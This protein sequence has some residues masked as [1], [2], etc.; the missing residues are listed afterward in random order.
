MR[1]R[2]SAYLLELLLL[3]LQQLALLLEVLI[4]LR[5][6]HKLDPRKHALT[7]L[8]MSDHSSR[9]RQVH[10]AGFAVHDGMQRLSCRYRCRSQAE[11][12]M[13]SEQNL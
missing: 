2:N 7:P 1:L 5:L 11:L 10:A 13:V 4:G 8:S 9:S 12:M 3:L 6:V